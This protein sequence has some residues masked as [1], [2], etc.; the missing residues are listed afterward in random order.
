MSNKRRKKKYYH[1]R[2]IKL[3]II[4]LLI[5][6][7]SIVLFF[8]YK[9]K[10]VEKEIV[11]PEVKEDYS[12]NQAIINTFAAYLERIPKKN[13]YKNIDTIIYSKFFNFKK[14][15][16]C[17]EAGYNSDDSV[18]LNKCYIDNNL[19]EE[20]YGEN[21]DIKK[22]I[23]FFDNEQILSAS[24]M[25]N[26]Y[27]L[28]NNLNQVIDISITEDGKLRY[29]NYNTLED[30]ILWQ[31]NSVKITGL[32]WYFKDCSSTSGFAFLTDSNTSY[33]ALADLL[34][35]SDVEFKKVNVYSPITEIAAL[36]DRS[37]TG[38]KRVEFYVKTND[39]FYALDD[40]YF[41]AQR[42]ND[43]VDYKSEIGKNGDTLYIFEN[44]EVAYFV[45][46]G[47]GTN[48]FNYVLDEHGNRIVMDN[49]FTKYS[50]NETEFYI[51]TKDKLYL[52]KLINHKLQNISLVS[53]LVKD[54]KV[55][56]NKVIFN[57]TDNTK[58]ELEVSEVY[59][60]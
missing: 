9:N 3:V 2:A 44:N 8:W 30:K 35:T 11:E 21:K 54:Y 55:N 48:E 4:L 6:Y 50:D 25:K 23:V 53:G 20:H 41:L 16:F 7:F 52:S 29:Y 51:L 42:Y 47:F 26:E 38:C 28:V 13:D 19:V 49:I 12:S 1:F 39:I 24:N 40:H 60:K 31:S 34:E 59:K 45:N 57:N 10:G 15:I 36:E 14:D 32:V 27:K 43:I 37:P 5:S 56:G 22:S 33:V 17:L 18:Y 46:L 58:V